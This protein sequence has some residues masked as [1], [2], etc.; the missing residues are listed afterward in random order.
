MAKRGAQAL[1]V[2]GLVNED[3]GTGVRFAAKFQRACHARAC[4]AAIARA[5]SSVVVRVRVRVRVG[6][7]V[8]ACGRVRARARVLARV[9]VRACGREQC[10]RR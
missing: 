2:G 10:S 8:S 1:R 7:C 6:S 5:P 4:T 9:R 3:L